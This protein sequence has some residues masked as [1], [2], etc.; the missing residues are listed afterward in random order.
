[1]KTGVA[2]L[3]GLLAGV[4]VAAGVLAAFVFVGPDPIG[5][6]PTPSP[7]PSPTASPAA[8]LSPS[9]GPSASAAPSATSPAPSASA[10]DQT[11]FH[12]GEPA[13]S[14]VVSQLGG[15]TIDL[16]ALKGSAVWVNFMQTTCP[17]CIDEFPLMN[18][19][20]SRY[21]SKGLVVIAVDVREDEGT[22]A[23][24]VNRLGATFP[25]GLDGDGKAQQAWG[26]LAMPIHFWIDKEGIV[27]AGALGGI[28]PV[29]M[30]EALRKVLP[31]VTI[32]P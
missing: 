20:K 14:L 8:S 27:R 5:L 23:S 32:T 28:G 12:V 17:E 15:G 26:V 29:V 21:S 1:M 24:F 6:R 13:P 3:A 2:I 22:V 9:V 7:T 10:G 19:F 4:L 18:S 16:V 11:G 31:G 25:V 30:A